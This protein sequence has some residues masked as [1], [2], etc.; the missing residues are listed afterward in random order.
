MF[1]LD[2][3]VLTHAISTSREHQRGNGG[4]HPPASYELTRILPL[5]DIII[6]PRKIK[7]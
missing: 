2:N 5:Y 1:P 4:F 6:I 7:K 3:A